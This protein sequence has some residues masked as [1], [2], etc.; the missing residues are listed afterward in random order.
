MPAQ[1]G[2][3]ITVVSKFTPWNG[4]QTTEYIEVLDSFG[5][6]LA[7]SDTRSP[8]N[9]DP[10]PVIP[11][12]KARWSGGKFYGAAWF[13]FTTGFPSDLATAVK[14]M[15]ASWRAGKRWPYPGWEG[16]S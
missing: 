2:N 12:A 16:L 10:A 15:A 7:T 11:D 1:N 9:L 4:S 13:A 3:D 8:T 6:S 5:V 14:W